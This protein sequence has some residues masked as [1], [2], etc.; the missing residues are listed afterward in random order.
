MNIFATSMC[1]YE[2]AYN[3]CDKHLY[4]QAKEGT[5]ML[6]SACL[7]RGHDPADMPIAKT[8]GR[9]HKGG[10]RNHP[11]TQ[12]TA[13]SPQ[14]WMWLWNHTMEICYIIKQRFGTVHASRDQLLSLMKTFTFKQKYAEWPEWN[15]TPF[16]VCVNQSKGENLDLLEMEATSAYRIFYHRD[17]AGFATWSNG[18]L[19][20]FWWGDE[21]YATA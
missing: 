7:I 19:P 1:P 15:R 2:S 4:S 5:Q 11:A 9:P 14:N 18:R 6:V 10:Y 17:K 13:E 21:R 3:L 8:T 12:W 16:A 20:P